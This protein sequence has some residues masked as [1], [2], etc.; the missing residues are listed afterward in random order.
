ME[1]GSFHAIFDARR[2]N[3]LKNK[4]FPTSL[5]D[6]QNSILNFINIYRF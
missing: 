4:Q 3:L 2:N 1:K 5:I 6:S